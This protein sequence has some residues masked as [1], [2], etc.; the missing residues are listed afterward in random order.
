MCVISQKKKQFL[1]QTGQRRWK[2]KKKDVD[3]RGQTMMRFSLKVTKMDC[4]R[5]EQIR[6]LEIEWSR[7]DSLDEEEQNS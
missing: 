1:Y 5:T 4:I 3:H 2:K 6:S 7:S